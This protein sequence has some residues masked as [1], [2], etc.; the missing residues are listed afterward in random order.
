MPDA[1]GYITGRGCEIYSLGLGPI[2]ALRGG[3]KVSELPLQ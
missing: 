1:I 3:R 2:L